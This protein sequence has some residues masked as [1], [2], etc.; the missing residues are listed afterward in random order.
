MTV[1]PRLTEDMKRHLVELLDATHWG[2]AN[3]GE[4]TIARALERRGYLRRNVSGGRAYSL[5]DEGREAG[6]ALR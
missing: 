2:P 1:A 3:S 6:E 5:T 4:W